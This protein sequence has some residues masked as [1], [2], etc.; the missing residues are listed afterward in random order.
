MRNSKLWY[1]MDTNGLILTKDGFE[2]DYL[3]KD[4]H[5]KHRSWN[6]GFR[7]CWSNINKQP[8]NYPHITR[9]TDTCKC[10]YICIYIY[11]TDITS[12]SIL[13]YSP[14]LLKPKLRLIKPR[15]TPQAPPFCLSPALGRCR[16]PTSHL[17][18]WI[19]N[20]KW[21]YKKHDKNVTVTQVLLPPRGACPQYLTTLFPAASVL[22]CE[23]GM[24]FGVFSILFPLGKTN[25]TRQH[26]VT[27]VH[28]NLQPHSFQHH[29][30]PLKLQLASHSH[31]DWSST[32]VLIQF[33]WVS[34]IQSFVHLRRWLSDWELPWV[35]LL[36]GVSRNK[37]WQPVRVFI[38]AYAISVHFWSSGI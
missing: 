5:H 33:Q 13:I 22:R 14:N 32:N 34:L 28:F 31:R 11:T 27:S 36:N 17:V 25:H 23:I 12:W 21:W 6:L 2:D 26:Q 20:R 38:V 35:V 8:R 16:W 30:I 24:F 19:H 4:I 37:F 7:G 15:P 18:N 9:D 3:Q 29:A 10:M 1:E